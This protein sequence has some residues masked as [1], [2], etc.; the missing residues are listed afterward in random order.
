MQKRLGMFLVSAVLLG[1]ILAGC[2]T[3]TRLERD[4]GTSY[5]LT[6][7][8]Q[9]LTPEAEQS[10]APQEDLDGGAAQRTLERY[11]KTFEKPPPPPT[12]AISVGAIK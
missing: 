4:Y 3:P 8:Q 7:A 11:R 9:I 12:F 2:T 10:L 5:Q 1:V 6:R